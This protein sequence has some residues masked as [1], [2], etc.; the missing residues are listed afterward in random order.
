MKSSSLTKKIFIGF[1]SIITF[2]VVVGFIYEQISR[3]VAESK[4]SPEGEFTEVRDHKLHYVKKGTGSP[5]VVF[6]AGVG[7]EYFLG[8]KYKIK[9]LSIHSGFAD[10]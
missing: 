2:I 7:M 8:L 1:L 3:L 6:D 9:S 4:F 10:L 5:T